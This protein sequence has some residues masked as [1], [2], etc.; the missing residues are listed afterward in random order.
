MSDSE[1]TLKPWE[2]KKIINS[3]SNFRNRILIKLLAYAGLRRFEVGKIRIED[4][5][6][7]KGRLR[8]VGKGN[9]LRVVPLLPELVGDIKHFIGTKKD[10]YLLSERGRSVGNSTINKIV[11]KAG[12]KAGVTNPNPKKKNINPHIFRHSLARNLKDKNVSLEIIQKIL[13]HTSQMVTADMY[14]TLSIDEVHEQFF[15]KMDG[16]N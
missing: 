7:D 6:F 12:Q 5:D 11:A 8:V 13:G 9:K 16:D 10:G 1:Y 15:K 14:G 2:I 4:I 3:S